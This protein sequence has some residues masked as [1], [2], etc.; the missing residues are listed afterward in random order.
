[1]FVLIFGKA[2]FDFAVIWAVYRA[3]KSWNKLVFVLNVTGK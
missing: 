1:M 2:N 3:I